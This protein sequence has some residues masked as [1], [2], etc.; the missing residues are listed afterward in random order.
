MGTLAGLFAAMGGLIGHVLVFFALR[1][2]IAR[3]VQANA[4]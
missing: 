3:E 2:L 4:G 1:F